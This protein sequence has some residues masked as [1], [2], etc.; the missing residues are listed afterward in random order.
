MPRVRAKLVVVSIKTNHWNPN[1]RV[2]ELNAQYDESIPEDQR[3]QKAT[4]SANF[5]ATVDNPGAIDELRL[6]RA[7]YVDMIPCDEPLR[8]EFNEAHG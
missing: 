5:T 6:G 1:Q 2:I 7:F 4:P 8:P 3:F